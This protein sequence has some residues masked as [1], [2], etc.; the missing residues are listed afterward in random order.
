VNPT[1]SFH[2]Q[3][4]AFNNP[5]Q[6]T[7]PRLFA[8]QNQP[9]ITTIDDDGDE[10]D[11][12]PLAQRASALP[13]AV[14]VDS[15]DDSPSL[16][17]GS[18]TSQ[19]IVVTPLEI[20]EPRFEFPERLVSQK[21]EPSKLRS[22]I[23]SQVVDESV[24]REDTLAALE[25]RG[26]VEA[27][28]DDDVPLGVTRAAHS[29]TGTLQRERTMIKRQKEKARKLE[30]AKAKAELEALTNAQKQTVE[31]NNTDVELSPK[32]EQAEKEKEEEEEDDDDVPLGM[33][34][35]V[36]VMNLTSKANAAAADDDDEE[37]DIPLGI[38]RH[39][40]MMNPQEA[41]MRKLVEQQNAAFGFPL[42]GPSH[43][44]HHFPN[45]MSM[46]MCPPHQAPFFQQQQYQFQVQ[47]Q[48][49]Q[50]QQQQQGHGTDAGSPVL[51]SSTIS[52][53]RQDVQ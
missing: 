10:D 47:Q 24:A 27:H 35:H 3:A 34:A 1:F 21:R 48:Q 19:N 25:G 5:Y 26:N 14:T 40:S 7:A 52:R 36:S 23:P 22:P 41:M 44:S 49:Q 31:G 30:A 16:D 39:T 53:W 42:A 51:D 50:H 38:N 43:P 17:I 15:Q 37:D 8:N 18:D 45:H 13:L 2:F 28:A 4:A 9:R 20:E 32:E 33:N 11:N 46:M 12:V 29:S 6:N